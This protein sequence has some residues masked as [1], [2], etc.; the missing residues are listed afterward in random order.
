MNKR[1]RPAD[2]GECR[3]VLE[4]GDIDHLSDRSVADSVELFSAISNETRYRILLLLVAAEE[5]VCGC[6]VE[7]HVDV[8]QST[9][10]QSLT[11]LRNA[12]LVTRTKD[13]R[14]RYY[15]STRTAERLIEL[16]DPDFDQIH[17]IAD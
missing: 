7:P 2:P 5:P 15:E 6:E 13:G 4:D 17:V 8:S 10:S 9:V 1:D 3:L 12:G 14:W 11:R 16:V